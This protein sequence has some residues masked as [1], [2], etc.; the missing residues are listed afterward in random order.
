MIECVVKVYFYQL[1]NAKGQKSI[2][3]VTVLNRNARNWSSKKE[4]TKK[5]Y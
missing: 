5:L 1:F 2:W 4:N 3:C